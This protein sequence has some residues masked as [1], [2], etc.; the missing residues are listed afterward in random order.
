MT[1]IKNL[2]NM[3]VCR[4][5]HLCYPGHVLA[6]PDMDLGNTILR[7]LIEHHSQVACVPTSPL[8]LLIRALLKSL[9]NF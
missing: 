1:S 5:H 6:G 7:I 4:Q 8:V 2:V 3:E 9:E